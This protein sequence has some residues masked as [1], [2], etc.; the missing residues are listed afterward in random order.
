MDTKLFK[1]INGFA[2]KVPLLDGFFK[3]FS[4]DYF[5]LIIVCLSLVWLWFGIRNIQQRGKTQKA[6]IAAILS[7]IIA[8][9]MVALCNA[10]YFRA[11]PF[12]ILPP[13]SVHLLFYKPTDSSFPSDFASTIFGAAMPIFFADKKSG[14]L[15]LTIALIASFGRIYIGIHYPLDVLGGAAF[16]ISAGIISWYIIK[17]LNPLINIATRYTEKIS[18]S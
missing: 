15:L 2:G 5:A 18:L 16:G 6:I 4:N 10:F 8:N 7:M 9:G 3:G 11:R 1:I 12:T 13:G 17:M 14:T